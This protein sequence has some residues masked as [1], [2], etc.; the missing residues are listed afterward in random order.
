MRP[1]IL[2]LALY[3]TTVLIP[4]ADAAEAR[5][6]WMD[7]LDLSPI[8]QGWGEPQARKSVVGGT[9]EMT[10]KT[11]DRGVGSHAPG[12]IYVELD[13]TA[14]R[15]QAVA[16]VDDETLNRGSITIKIYSDDKKLF[17]SGVLRGGQPP[18]EIDLAIAGAKRL[19]LVMGQGGDDQSYD[20]VDWADA[21]FTV[22]GAA[23]T[24]VP[25]P[26]E[27][28]VIRTPA[29]PN[30]PRINGTRVYGVRPGSPFIYRIPA[31]GD[32][33]M[34]FAVQNL[35]GG[36]AVDENQGII[37]GSIA[38]RTPRSYDMTF[39]A[40][41]GRG[42]VERGFRIVVGG[43]LALTPPMGWNHWYTFYQT[44][45]GEIVRQ[46]ADAMVTSGMADAG[47]HYVN[48]DDC[49]MNAPEHADPNRVGPLR[50]ENG[51][52]LPNSY[53]PDMPALV[54]YIHAKGLKA[55]LYTSPGPLT[56]GRFAG[57]Y[58]HERQDA[59]LYAR[60]GFDF[61]KYDWCSYSEV[62]KDD[63][64]EELKKPYILM[65]DILKTLD[66][67]IVLNLCQYGMGDVWKWGEEVGGQCWRTA[68]DLGFE[69]DRYHAV[70]QRNAGF[71]EYAHP[72]AWN[73]PDY[74]LLGV[75]GSR[76]SDWKP[77]PCPLTPNQQ[78]SYM[79]LWVLMASPLFFTG[80][81]S[82]LDAFTLN[83]LC[84]PEVVDINQDPLGD[85]GY[86][87]IEGEEWEVWEKKLEDGSAAVGLFNRSEIAQTVT[88]RWKDL[89][90]EGR[91]AVRDVWRQKDLGEFDEEFSVEVGRLGVELLRVRPAK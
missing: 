19:V 85:Q 48:I 65:G 91:Q 6:V 81:M 23:P 43:K 15:F 7:E 45:T 36:L 35:P 9:I 34:R 44:I 79:S 18:V 5:T 63:S 49:W 46:A 2:S 67:D 84:N 64:L 57:S 60:W 77:A 47:Y 72:G 90:L 56:C 58:G 13:G 14:E 33:P 39:V 8:R 30:E 4:A 55:G 51:N 24:I 75:V 42:T 10:G 22:A 32:R 54:E 53:F 27:E 74:L 82:R 31:T 50:D 17:E 89:K 29:P 1:A 41:N 69:L 62:A 52:M 12:V 20:H 88:A 40:E 66:R 61:L 71:R 68:G 59:E 73:D 78:Y 16:G 21:R 26:Q 80:D 38:D 87:V 76:L 3:A 28:Q 37:S 11:F 86:P 70:A 25:R 83:V